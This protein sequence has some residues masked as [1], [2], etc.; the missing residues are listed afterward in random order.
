LLSQGSQ[1]FFF[2]FSGWWSVTA[3]MHE[4]DDCSHLFDEAAAIFAGQKVK[5]DFE[6]RPKA[7]FAIDEFV[8]S[9]CHLATS[10]QVNLPSPKLR[11]IGGPI[12]WS[13]R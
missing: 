3:L 9:L 11:P 6:C 4:A 13:M 5:S 1:K 8:G 12:S 2:S 7:K 10:K